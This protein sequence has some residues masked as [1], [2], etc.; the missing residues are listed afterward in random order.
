MRST[1]FSSAYSGEL[2]YFPT[3]DTATYRVITRNL[4]SGTPFSIPILPG[5]GLQ[6]RYIAAVNLSTAEPKFNQRGYAA[7]NMFVNSL[8]PFRCRLTNTQ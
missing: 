2:R 1:G 6:N 8:I 5:G 3:N 7:V 4:V